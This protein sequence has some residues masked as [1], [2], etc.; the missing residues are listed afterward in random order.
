MHA[1]GR[2]LK[3]A[4]E[5]QRMVWYTSSPKFDARPSVSNWKLNLNLCRDTRS[6]FRDWVSSEVTTHRNGSWFSC[7]WASVCVAR[8]PSTAQADGVN[9]P[10]DA[11]SWQS[12]E[13]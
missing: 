11:I 3:Y 13:A 12:I 5:S 2:P 9:G 1:L 7:H 10:P 8:G 6:G 4:A